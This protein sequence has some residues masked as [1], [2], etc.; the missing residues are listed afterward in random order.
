MSAWYGIVAPKKTPE[1][2]IGRLNK[3]INLGLGDT[4]MTAR[5]AV[6]GSSALPFSPAA[7]GKFVGDE[8]EK[9]TKVAKFARI[10]PE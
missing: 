6:L 2:I 4:G 5:L 3:A 10:K 7:L 8:I 9:W 1:E